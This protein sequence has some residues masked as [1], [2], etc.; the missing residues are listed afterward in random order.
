[1]TVTARA[2]GKVLRLDFAPLRGARVTPQ[3]FLRVDASLGR[4]GVFTY[5]TPLGPRR[6]L[7]LPDEVFRVDSVATAAG[8]VVTDLHPPRTD[9]FITPGNWKKWA[10]GFVGDDVHQD[11]QH[12]LGSLVIQDERVLDLV[13]KGERREVSP[14]YLC[15]LEPKSGHWDGQPYD[16]IQ[17][18]IT[19]NSIGIGPRGWGRQG[20]DV[21][22]R[23]DSLDPMAAVLHHDGTA[24][25]DFLRVKML[26]KHL[27]VM[28]LAEATGIVIPK[29]D[30]EDPLLRVG[31]MP[32]RG[33]V[34]EA[35]LE[36]WTPRPS[37]E[38][39]RAL[40]KE[41]G[42]GIDDLLKL[43][44][45]ELRQDSKKS[46]GAPVKGAASS[47]QTKEKPMAETELRLDG[48]TLKLDERDAALVQKAIDERDKKIKDLT[49][50]QSALQ[51]RLDGLT[52]QHG[53][54][55]KELDELP[56]KLRGEMAAR[57][58][59]ESEARRVLGSDVKLDGKSDRQVR[60]QVLQ[61]LNPELKLDALDDRYV[62]VRFDVALEGFK[63][64]SASEKVR[65]AITGGSNPKLRTDSKDAPD[66]AAARAKM[67]EENN[68]AWKRPSN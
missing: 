25:G 12:L 43:I 60:E 54:L 36:G 18:G 51:A 14:G 33:H 1:V 32:N 16:C 28:Q 21:A 44:P 13:Q 30:E 29:I 46:T 23:L 31:H 7:R 15:T 67:I 5:D 34:L 53:K 57:A 68:N 39:L 38:Q 45:E 59:L 11:G 65:Q 58:S 62:E 19:Y 4:T 27:T 47:Q 40:A 50:D 61:K 22:L 41:L 20:S 48:L 42:V 64:P 49:G 35:I 24:L 66:P 10:I 52:E 26:E 6:E 63:E 2:D 9:A 37:D 56:V 8:A 17:R 55:K 3:G